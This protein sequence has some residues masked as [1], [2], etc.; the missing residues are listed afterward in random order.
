MNGSSNMR[1]KIHAFRYL[2]GGAS[3]TVLC[4]GCVLLFVEFYHFHYLLSTN[5]ATLVAYFYSYLVNKHFVFEDK[6]GDDV[7]KGSKFLVLQLC[8]LLFA[9]AFMFTSV[10]LLGFHYLMPVVLVS[11]ITAIIG[12]TVMRLSI[13]ETSN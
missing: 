12:F 11:V 3:T 5:L 7:I 1:Y 6:N 8:L 10:T 2:I 13:F 9:N 4:W